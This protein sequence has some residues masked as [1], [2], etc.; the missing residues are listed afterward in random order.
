MKAAHA[1]NTQNVANMSRAFPLFSFFRIVA[2]ASVS[3]YGF[4]S[5]INTKLNIWNFFLVKKPVK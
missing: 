3:S 5:Y 4:Q 2:Y 1:I